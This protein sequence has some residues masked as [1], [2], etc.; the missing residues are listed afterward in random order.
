MEEE[1]EVMRRCQV[2]ATSEEEEEEGVGLRTPLCLLLPPLKAVYFSVF[3]DFF[4]RKWWEGATAEN[5][6]RGPGTGDPGYSQPDWDP[7]PTRT[8]TGDGLFSAVEGGEGGRGEERGIRK[9]SPFF[10]FEGLK[11]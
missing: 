7:V 2:S 11:D 1:E 4:L 3:D 8:G 5:K 10:Y 9:M 6:T